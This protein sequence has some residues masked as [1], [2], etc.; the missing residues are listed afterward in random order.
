MVMFE[1][2]AAGTPV[3]ATNHGG[4]PE[5]MAEDVGV[6]FEP[7][8]EGQETHN[9]DGLAEAILEGLALSERPGI[10]QRCRAHAGRF[11]WSA[12]GPRIEAMY[13]ELGGR[14]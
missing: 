12:L 5:F 13:E 2:W 11:S 3:V 14:G 10:R 4:P 6:L 9:A 8:T 7:A 1:A